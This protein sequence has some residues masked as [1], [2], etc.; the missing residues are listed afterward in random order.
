MNE[1]VN[2]DKIERAI[3]AEQ[4]LEAVRKLMN[5]MEAIKVLVKQQD[6][7]LKAMNRAGKYKFILEQKVGEMY[8]QIRAEHGNKTSSDLTNKQQISRDIGATRQTLNNWAKERLVPADHVEEFEAVCNE[9]GKELTSAGLWKYHQQRCREDDFDKL[10][11]EKLPDGKYRVIYAD[12]PWLYSKSQNNPNGL[13]SYSSYGHYPMM[14]TK[15]IAEIRVQDLAADDSVL[16]LW[17]TSPK[18]QEA[19]EVMNAWRFDYKA[20]FVWD[21]MKHNV[22]HYNSVQHE[23]LLIGTHGSCMPDTKE[24]QRSIVAIERGAHS[25]KPE[26]F[27][28]LIDVLYE[29]G[30]RIELFARREEDD[31]WDTWG[32]ENGI[33]SDMDGGRAI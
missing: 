22:G 16:F 28:D 23:L 32:L 5:E 19:L 20:M 3:N 21:K 18:V 7:S 8:A 2:W 14:S 11:E 31:V 4:D 27:R 33:D 17:S 25:E 1:L 9:H 13:Q 10:E 12:P 15:E 24:L 30:P 26:L 6:D 29:W